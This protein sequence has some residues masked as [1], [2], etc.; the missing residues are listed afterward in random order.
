MKKLLALVLCV[1]MFVSVLSTAAFA[2]AEQPFPTTTATAKWMDLNVANKAI[3]NTKKNI[4]YIYGSL[5][6]DNA[7]F[8]TVKAM[9]SVVT[10]LVKGLFADLEDGY[11]VKVPGGKNVYSQSLLEKNA[12]RVL[13]N[14]LGGEVASYMYDHLGSYADVS[15]H[16]ELAGGNK[17]TST[18][19]GNVNGYTFYTT[20]SGDIYAVKSGVPY[21]VNMDGVTGTT[22]EKLAQL[23]T[24][25]PGRFTEISAANYTLVQDY[26]YDPIKYA[27]AFATAVTKA[28]SSEKG[29]ANI[30]A[31]AYALMQA[32]IAKDVNDKMDDLADEIAK[33]EDGTRILGQYG[34][35]DFDVFGNISVDPYAF[36]DPTNLP[37]A[38]FNMP[39]L[40]ADDGTVYFLAD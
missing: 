15:T 21:I 33:W 29:A 19:V 34:F 31:Y 20:A 22:A 35:A 12:K 26:Q 40:L 24:A 32:K 16:I 10:D 14:A 39:G 5:A 1:M 9:D 25:G 18:G 3:S 27:N 30:S 23:Q 17:L 6:A 38:S 4:E 7:V 13:R 2:D 28:L 11:S 8:G 36:I 37:K